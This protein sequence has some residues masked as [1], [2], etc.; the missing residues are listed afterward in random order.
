MN[1][2]SNFPSENPQIGRAALHPKI[3]PHHM[4]SLDAKVRLGSP[5]RGYEKKKNSGKKEDCKELSQQAR[6][7]QNFNVRMEGKEKEAE[8]GDNTDNTTEQSSSQHLSYVTGEYQ[9]DSYDL[10]SRRKNVKFQ[11]KIEN[12]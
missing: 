10:F 4:G 8:E 11:E 12:L 5:E 2:H 1:S 3:D 9:L 6:E 7:V